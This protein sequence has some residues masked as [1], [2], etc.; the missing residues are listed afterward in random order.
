[1]CVPVP[2]ILAAAGPLS[3][4][5][6][7]IV[8]GWFG[9][10]ARDDARQRRLKIYQDGVEAGSVTAARYLYG[11]QTQNVNG[12]EQDWYAQAIKDEERTRP[13]VMAAGKAL[14]GLFDPDGE[15][16][17]G[18][19]IIAKEIAARVGDVTSYAQNAAGSIIQDFGA[20]LTAAAANKV[21]PAGTSQRINI[22]TSTSTLLLVGLVVLVGAAAF[23]MRR[24]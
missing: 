24:K 15:E 10:G 22:P 23:V 18:A 2:A 13:E 16:I 17:N 11:Q 9:G 1:V 19:G 21:S 3:G 20:G 14:G 6:Q 4:K 7:S 12:H 5:A 8:S